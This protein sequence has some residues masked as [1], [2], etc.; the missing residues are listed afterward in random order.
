M[1]SPV[2]A[3]SWRLLP[4]RRIEQVATEKK[5]SVD[6]FRAPIYHPLSEVGPRQ[7]VFSPPTG[8]MSFQPKDLCSHRGLTP[9]ILIL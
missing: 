8:W 5:A 2:C 6:R 9:R 4:R 1:T 3:C 7:S